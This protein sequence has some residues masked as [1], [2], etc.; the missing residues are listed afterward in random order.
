MVKEEKVSMRKEE[1]YKL[2]KDSISFSYPVYEKLLKI[3]IKR[4]KNLMEERKEIEEII[5]KGADKLFR[6]EIEILTSIRGIAKE[7]AI[8]FMAEVI[9]IK[10][11]PNKAKLIYPR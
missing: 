6:R 8:Y 9:D 11:F 10:R 7:S 5:K 2:A 3:K 4:L 1:I